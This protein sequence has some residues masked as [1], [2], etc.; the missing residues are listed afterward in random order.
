M[1]LKDSLVN[2]WRLDEASGTRADAMGNCDLSTV[3]GS[4]T[5]AAGVQGDAISLDGSSSVSRSGVAHPFAGADVVNLSAWVYP[6]SIG[7]TAQAIVC[8]SN[9]GSALSMFWRFNITTGTMTFSL[10]DTN[11]T[12]RTVTKTGPSNDVWTHYFVR[13]IRN[14]SLYAYKNLDTAST[15]TVGD[16]AYSTNVTTPNTVL[17]ARA[18]TDRFIGRID[19]LSVWTRDLSAA[20]RTAVYNAGAGTNLLSLHRK[21]SGFPLA[22]KV[23]GGLA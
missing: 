5:S 8:F 14:D 1:A 13:F 12:T 15:G 7:S 9:A 2:L 6:T 3:T 20:E 22:S 19:Q 23:Y 10:V 21:A 4:P 11:G 18:S 17:G 16:F